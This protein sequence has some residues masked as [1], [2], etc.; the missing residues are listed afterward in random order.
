MSEPTTPERVIPIPALCLVLLIG[1]SGS[2]KST[3]AARHFAPT[4]V[5]SSDH[6]RAVV[7]DDATDQAATT[8]AFALVQQI[9][10][11]R[12]R[13]GRLTVIDATNVKPQD[14][15]GFLQIA[16]AQ[17]VLAVA[18]VLNLDERISQDRNASRPDRAFGPQV[19]RNHVNNLRR[20]LRGLEKEGFRYVT[21]LNSPAEVD[22][23]R[24]IR[25]PLYS[26][27]RADHGPYDIIG[28]IHGCYD[29]TV[30]LLAKLG[31]APDDAAIWRHPTGRRVIF[32]GDL[33][34]RGP[35]SIATVDLVRRMVLADAALCVP[36]NHDMKL[37]RYLSGHSV[38]ITHGLETTIAA[39][40][41]L[42][43][44]TRAQWSQATRDFFTTLTSHYVLD[45]GKL[46]VAHAGMKEA[47]QGRSSGRVRA[48]ALY[49]ETT[50][51]TD[52]LGMPIRGDWAAD[53]RG[54]AAV[55][56]GHTAV[57][58]PRWVNNTI[59]IDTGCV[60]GGKLTA[61]R[62]PEREIVQVA[63]H[64]EYAVAK[65]PIAP[66]QPMTST[67][68]APDALLRLEDVQGKQF[69]STGLLG[70][71]T[72]EADRAAAALE[73][74]SRFAMD[75]R[76]L[77]YLPP[78]MSPSETARQDD[79]LEHPDQAFGYYRHGGVE[80]IICE[81]KHMG[82]RAILVVCRD[83][84]TAARRF[85]VPA[86]GPPGACY[87]RTGRRFFDDDALD[88]AFITRVCAALSSANAWD[89]YATDWVCI[90][91]EILPWNVKARD[92]IRT[93]Y[94]PV[95]AAGSAAITAA[96]AAT[97]AAQARGID[98]A[99]L[100]ARLH[101][102]QD[103][104]AR[105]TAAYRRYNWEVAGLDG[106]RVA[107]FHLLATEGH[108]NT[109]H[110]HLWHLAELARL[111]EADDL[112]LATRHQSVAVHDTAS[113]AAATDWW[114]S[115]TEA[116]GEGMVVKPLTF[117]ARQGR[118]L[119]QPAVKCRGRDYLRII[120]GPDYLVP[121]NLIRLR[122][123]NLATKR[124]LA[125]REFALGIEALTR[126]TQAEPLYRVHQPVF[127]VLALESEPVDPRL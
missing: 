38:Q 25:E 4:E 32:L 41:D 87:T 53:Y 6:Y 35:Q 123:R 9:A 127:G 102:Q 126:F 63:A 27:K 96:I 119:L 52:D 57:D 117:T 66:A 72:I 124:S 8:D 77:I 86:D 26:D 70:K 20:N 115:L 5:L 74:M 93:Q 122:Q 69:I 46:V 33:V 88:A 62:W 19:V 31:Y 75:P 34:D 51:E 67:D 91:A 92:L 94:A 59:D 83:A 82:S 78:T 68:D 54:T 80:T 120:Y 30:E 18:I 97:N 29:E 81:E 49:G 76:W 60:Y 107:P 100:T 43:E 36:G 84:A 101:Q 22:A 64:A 58:E 42:S 11:V 23:V 108:V 10:S 37:V 110:D 15:A 104:I 103:D 56:Y 109:D 79:Y 2:G 65:H 45:A 106:L 12:L 85:G 28:D 89:R 114:Q 21:I 125:L 95:A 61:L 17:D 13:R 73:V 118:K 113:C 44:E 3:F 39:L 90:D 71:V 48:F 40:E 7:S 1:A 98:L 47:Y 111:A 105:Y 24:F 116:G 16:R 121:D 112:F 99:P 50:G 14:R 55:V